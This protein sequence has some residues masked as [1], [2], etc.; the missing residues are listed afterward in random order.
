MLSPKCASVAFGMGGRIED[1][2]ILHCFQRWKHYPVLVRQLFADDTRLSGCCIV[3]TDPSYWDGGIWPK[4]VV[5]YL[6]L[7]FMHAACD[8]GATSTYKERLRLGKAINSSSPKS[9]D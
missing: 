5:P 9:M 7:G 6:L 4:G 2:K 1:S 3:L 8:F